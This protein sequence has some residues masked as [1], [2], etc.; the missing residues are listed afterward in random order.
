[1][2]YDIQLFNRKDFEVKLFIG[3]DTF[4]IVSEA[5]GG[6]AYLHKDGT[7][8]DHCGDPNFFDTTAE[9]YALLNRIFFKDDILDEEL[10]TI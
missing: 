2:K 10:F 9:A 7:L 3:H 4:F 6:C 8:R 1:M 5:R